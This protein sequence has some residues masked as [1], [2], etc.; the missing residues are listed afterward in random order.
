MCTTKFT[1][2][3]KPSGEAMSLNGPNNIR[4]TTTTIIITIMIKVIV[5]WNS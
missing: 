4:L 2:V 5:D 1:K 3:K